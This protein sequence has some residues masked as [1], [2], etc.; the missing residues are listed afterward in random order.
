MT[1]AENGVLNAIMRHRDKDDPISRKG[2]CDAVGHGDR[3]VRHM[4]AH[5]RD[6]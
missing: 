4:I 6:G 2:L 1:P 3:Q 5:L